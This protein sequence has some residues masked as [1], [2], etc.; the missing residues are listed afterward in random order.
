MSNF[1]YFDLNFA[2]EE[3]LEELIEARRAF[4][5][6]DVTNSIRLNYNA[7]DLSHK[8][9]KRALNQYM[10]FDSSSYS[11]TPIEVTLKDGTKTKA[12]LY[13]HL[14]DS[15][16]LDAAYPANMRMAVS[17]HKDV[18][19]ITVDDDN[20]PV[21]EAEDSEC[22]FELDDDDNDAEDVPG[23]K[24]NARKYTLFPMF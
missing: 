6:L 18:S 15:W 8:E 5:A 3:T 21:D 22:E 24:P 7:S 14:S 10:K 9:V 16:D 20:L 13:H 11:K 4:T 19:K 23:S 2:L 1:D 12:L 17:D